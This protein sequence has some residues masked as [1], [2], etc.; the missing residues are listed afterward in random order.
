MC[1][2]QPVSVAFAAV[3]WTLCYM[4][5]KGPMGCRVCMASFAAMETLQAL[6]Y[7]W[8]EQCDH[9]M[10]KVLTLLGFV[11]LAFQPFFTNLYLGAFMN[12]A[13]KRYLPLI[14]T[15]CVFAGVMMC[16]RMW[17]TTGDHMCTKG[18]E[19]MCGMKTCTFNG[20]THLAWQMPLQHCD[21]D[22]FTPGFTLHF[23]TFFLPSFALGMWKY[24][25]FF[26][27]SGPFT[28]RALTDHQD[29]IPSIWCFFSI[30][31]LL[32]PLAMKYY[33]DGNL[34]FTD[35]DAKAANAVGSYTNGNGHTNGGRQMNGHST[36][37]DE[38]EDPIGGY[39]GMIKRGLILM[40][41][42]TIKR[43]ATIM[44]APKSFPIQA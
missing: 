9:P 18:I 32:L 6:Q 2:T 11:H 35:A 27:F 20:H 44:M 25:L 5:K 12:K 28:G 31:Q 33:Q 30:A 22:Y 23:F 17:M 10:N 19:S 13:Q 4:W 42:L 3:L 43:F 36:K 39:T 8:I 14:L 1:F 24:T 37:R 16:N 15:M 26:L 40:A 29:E 7:I 34:I 21:Q 38:E 41:C